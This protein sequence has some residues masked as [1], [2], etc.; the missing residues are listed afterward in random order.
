LAPT[1]ELQFP[2]A[3]VAVWQEAGDSPVVPLHEEVHADEEL[4]LVGQHAL[5]CHEE[6]C[7]QVAPHSLCR[8]RG[9]VHLHDDDAVAAFCVECGLCWL[10]WDFPT[11]L[12]IYWAKNSGHWW[13]YTT[14]NTLLSQWYCASQSAKM[15]YSSV[16]YVSLLYLVETHWA[17][18]K[19]VSIMMI[20]LFCRAYELIVFVHYRDVL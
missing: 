5:A 15:I 2:I 6:H 12:C 19:S 8:C 11:K 3:V 9:G 13:C 18:W 20:N 10:Y 1:N 4:A 16:G 7:V 14:Y 17:V